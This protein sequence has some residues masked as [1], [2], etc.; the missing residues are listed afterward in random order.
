MHVDTKSI[1][2]IKEMIK[3]DRKLRIVYMPIYKSYQDPLVMYYLNYF[4]EQELGFTFG[5]YEDSPKIPFVDT[6]LK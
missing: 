1:D 6:F 5:H 2:N 4:T 3:T